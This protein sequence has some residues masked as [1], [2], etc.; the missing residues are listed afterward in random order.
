MSNAQ[1]YSQAATFVPPAEQLKNLRKMLL[2]SERK[3]AE[4]ERQRDALQQR[5]SDSDRNRTLA[6]RQRDGLLEAVPVYR[7]WFDT[8]T[9]TNTAHWQELAANA[10]GELDS[11]IAL[12]EGR[13][14]PGWCYSCDRRNNDCACVVEVKS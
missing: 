8:C 10:S 14:D 2:A 7:Y 3:L 6:E 11:A 13:Q 12:A 1:R 4:V 5:L 9:R